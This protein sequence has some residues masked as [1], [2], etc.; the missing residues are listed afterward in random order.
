MELRITESSVAIT[1][2][3]SVNDTTQQFLIGASPGAGTSTGRRWHGAIGEILIYRGEIPSSGI[4]S[5]RNYLADKWG[6]SL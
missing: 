2:L 6:V 1:D 3:N 4:S 5:I